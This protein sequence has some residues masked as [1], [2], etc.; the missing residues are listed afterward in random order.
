MKIQRGLEFKIVIIAML[1][2]MLFFVSMKAECGIR[3]VVKYPA[4]I[5]Y[6][7]ASN[8]FVQKYVST[9]LFVFGQGVADAKCD[10][11]I[12]DNLY[13]DKQTY[14]VSEK[15]WHFW[16]NI[17]RITTWTAIGLKALAVGQGNMT[18]YEAVFRQ[19]SEFPIAN[20]VWH[21]VYYKTRYNN[22]WD[23][24]HSDRYFYY[25]DPFNRLRD[26][27]VSLK[28]NQVFVADG[29]QVGLGI[30]GL[31]ITEIRW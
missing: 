5:T 13:G 28:G 30:V 11:Y 26:N 14:G 21:K 15:N 7:V 29:I 16:K 2:S 17:G 31:I 22:Y 19:C 1:L 9:A 12:W 10:G 8:E 6:K 3:D 20:V 24:E 4:K 18:P 25:P 23:T 27:Y